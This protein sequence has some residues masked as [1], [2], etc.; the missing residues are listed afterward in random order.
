[1]LFVRLGSVMGRH[2]AACMQRAEPLQPEEPLLFVVL[3]ALR[4]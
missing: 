3:A 2:V 1:M 4:R